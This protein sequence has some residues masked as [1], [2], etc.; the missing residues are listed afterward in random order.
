M[1]NN[2]NELES[3]AKAIYEPSEAKQPPPAVVWRSRNELDEARGVILA[4]VRELGA[5]ALLVAALG[6]VCVRRA[7]LW[8][9]Q[10]T[11]VR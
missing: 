2:L 5:A 3:R 7:W 8:L 11:S 6:L 1:L 4:A 9:R 10:W